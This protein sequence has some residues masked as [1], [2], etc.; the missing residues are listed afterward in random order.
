MEFFNSHACLHQP[1]SISRGNIFEQL[2]S[3]A[4]RPGGK[5]ALERFKTLHDYIQLILSKGK[6]RSSTGQTGSN[7][8]ENENAGLGKT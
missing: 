2:K 1:S 3:D 4:F 6:P 5:V 8:W 7:F